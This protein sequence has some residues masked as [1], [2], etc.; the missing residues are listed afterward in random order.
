M[1]FFAHFLDGISFSIFLLSSAIE[2]L[3]I[4]SSTQSA[5]GTENP[6]FGRSI[7]PF[8]SGLDG[9]VASAAFVNF[10]GEIDA[11][12]ASLANS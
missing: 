3:E 8:G 2:E 12:G 9:E 11:I 6:V 1:I 10:G 4:K 5:I 7:T